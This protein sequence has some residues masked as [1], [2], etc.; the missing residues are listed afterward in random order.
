[1][2]DMLPRPTPRAAF[3]RSLRAQLMVQAPSVLSPRESTWSRVTG[4]FLRPALRPAMVAAVIALL[5]FASAGKAAAD[6]LPGDAAFGL[7]VAA[8]QL[9]LALALDDTTRLRLLA[10]QADHRLAELAEAV[11]TRPGSAP[12][13]TDAYAAAIQRFTDALDALQGKPGTSAD[14]QT[15][16][17]DVVDAAHLRHEAVLDELERTAPE[18]AQEG[19]ERAREEA[20]KL[21][22]SGRP[23][24]TPEPNDTAEPTR[25]A[26]TPTPTRAVEPSRGSL[27]TGTTDHH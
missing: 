17:D 24:R 26:R 23:A 20:D 11:S 16:A 18:S 8:E 1:M 10:E 7:K 4:A 13:A 5:V 14:K 21:H 12:T 6:S 2:K 15:A 27:P 9:Q 22:A 25:A 19:L 3:K